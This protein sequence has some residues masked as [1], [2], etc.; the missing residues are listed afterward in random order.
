[1]ASEGTV[2]VT[3]LAGFLGAGKTTLL[4]RIVGS[5]ELGRVAVV[6]NEFGELGIDGSLVV[7]ADEDVV[8]LRNGCVCCTVR[9]D[10][11]RTLN[12][13]LARRRALLGRLRFDRIVIELSGMASPGPVVQTMVVDDGLRDALHLDGIVTLAN[14]REV[15]RQISAHPEAAAQ[16]GYADLLVLN[17]TDGVDERGLEAARAALRSINGVA[18]IR[19]SVRG[20]LPIERLSGLSSGD[21]RTWSLATT[22]V[23]DDACG[24]AAHEHST[25]VTTAA[26]ETE[27]QI[28]L[29][30]LKV[31]LQF[32]SSRRDAE[33]IR[34]K[35]IVSCAGQ[36]RA[37]VVQSVYQWLEIGPADFEPPDRSRLV[38]IGRGLDLPALERGWRTLVA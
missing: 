7:G 37:V 26:F 22:H 23:C 25:D 24:H 4:N 10:L 12:R 33:L 14:A 13:L 17:H 31:W 9:G 18:D 11:S 15:G 2:P 21:A 38:V 32:V 16:V 20:E 8:E 27:E 36:S 34:L 19:T 5:E 29:H 35:G 30:K 28:D 6:V 1:M 3:L